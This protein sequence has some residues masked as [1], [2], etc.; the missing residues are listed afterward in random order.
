MGIDE[1][2]VDVVIAD[3]LLPNA[4]LL[5]LVALGIGAHA[6]LVVVQ[7]FVH[8]VPLAHLTLVVLHHVGDMVLHDVEGFL[9]RPVLI[10]GLTAVA[11]NPRGRLL[12][13]HQAV[14]AHHHLFVGGESYNLLAV[15]VEVEPAV[16]ASEGLRLHIVLGHEHI[17]L[18]AYG[19]GLGQARVGQVVLIERDGRADVLAVLIGVVFQ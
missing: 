15:A 7:A 10:V 16:L 17:E 14:A 5:Q 12:V 6:R 3:G 18:E 4:V 19:L 8:H 2:G 11:G 9:A 13:P 1:C